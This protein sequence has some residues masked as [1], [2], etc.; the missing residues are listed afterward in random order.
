[1]A[2]VNY[3]EKLQE[4]TDS[5]KNKFV[6]IIT[7]SIVLSVLTGIYK[8][9]TPIKYTA[10]SIFYPDKKEATLT[11]SPL[12]LIQGDIAQKAGALGILS[13]VVVSRTVSKRIA[14]AKLP[15]PYNS[16]YKSLA[17]WIIADNNKQFLPWQQKADLKTLKPEQKISKASTILRNGCVSIIDENGFMS[18]VNFAFDKDL[19]LTENQIIIDELIK[20]NF[21]VNTLKV[22]QDLDYITHRTD[23]IRDIYENLKYQNAQFNDVNKYMIKS[24]VKVPQEDLEENKKIIAARYSRLLEMQDQALVRYQSDKPIIKILDL[25]YL[26]GETSPPVFIT[27][28]IVFVATLFASLIFVCRKIIINIIRDEIEGGKIISTNS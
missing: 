25:P 15:S 27:A 7:I 23:S 22:K 10:K 1:M 6:W 17:E 26:D 5:I 9:L 4:A 11:G 12:E 20:F 3:S 21:E 13:K 18:L 14:S 28:F 16:Q 19:A 2:K 8:N 24:V